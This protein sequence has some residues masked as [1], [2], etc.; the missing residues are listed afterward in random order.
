MDDAVIVALISAAASIIVA[1]IAISDPKE[2]QKTA[3]TIDVPRKVYDKL[4]E[5]NLQLQEEN[6]NLKKELEK[7]ENH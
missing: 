4:I 1:L 6:R 2:H 7:Y 5:E 3:T